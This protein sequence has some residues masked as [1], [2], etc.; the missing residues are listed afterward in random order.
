MKL[1]LAFFVI[2]LTI[3]FPIQTNSELTIGDS[4]LYEIIEANYYAEIDSEERSFNGYRFGGQTHPVGTKFNATAEDVDVGSVFFRFWLEGND[5]YTSVAYISSNWFNVFAVDISYTT[6]QYTFLAV[7]NINV[8]TML[9]LA[10]FQFNPY[11]HLPHN[12]YLFSLDSLGEDIHYFFNRWF[13]LYPGIECLY[14]HSV[15]N[16]VIQFESWVGGKI[17]AQFGSIITAGSNL[18]T[19]ISFGD[20]Y[21]FAVDNE[22]GVVIGWGQRGWVKGTINGKAVKISMEWEYELEG[23]ELQPYQLGEMKEFGTGS[24]YLAIFLPMAVV[25]A[26]IP[27][28]LYFMKKKSNQNF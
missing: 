5:T 7:E 19:D 4:F 28:I 8:L 9:D 10:Y 17:D 2:L 26:I 3:P 13:Y 12:D 6:L 20:S 27:V 14:E 1:K 15:E 21:H 23:Y 16:G 11:I 25:V 24:P 22:T 18:P